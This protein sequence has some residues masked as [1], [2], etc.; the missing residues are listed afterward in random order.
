ME[1]PLDKP[2]R[3]RRRWLVIVI[4]LLALISLGTWAL[5]TPIDP[6]LIGEWE[7]APAESETSKPPFTLQIRADGMADHL[8]LPSFAHGAGSQINLAGPWPFR[9]SGNRFEVTNDRAVGVM[10]VVGKLKKLFFGGPP[11]VFVRAR[12]LSVDAETL[13]LDFDHWQELKFVRAKDGTL[14]E[15]RRNVTD[16]RRSFDATVYTRARENLRHGTAPEQTGP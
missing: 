14:A 8:Y 5:W 4:A 1:P 9:V 12:I 6:R 3:K 2:L 13:V 15:R 11:M 7:L 16:P 10:Q